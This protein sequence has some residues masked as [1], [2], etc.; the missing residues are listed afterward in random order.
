LFYS[1][2]ET[3]KTYKSIDNND[4]MSDT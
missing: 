4:I 3:N 1:K 2:A